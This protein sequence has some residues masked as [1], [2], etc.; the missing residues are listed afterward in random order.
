MFQIVSAVPLQA[1]LPLCILMLSFI[2]KLVVDRTAKLPDVINAL[3]EL[4]VSIAFLATS[5]I[6]AT[7]MANIG[8]AS[9][10]LVGFG[11]YIVGTVITVVTWRR[12]VFLFENNHFIWA[13][14]VSGIGY[15][16][17]ILG[18]LN[19]IAII[20]RWSK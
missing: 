12:S 11:I 20:S 7:A 2:L 10:A 8:V 3:F 6:A 1:V 16:I 4:P 18:L 19:A 14:I 13:V 17:C 9:Y 15:A 5:L